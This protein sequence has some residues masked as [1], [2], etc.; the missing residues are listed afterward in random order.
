ME[1]E[2]VVITEFDSVETSDTVVLTPAPT[3]KPKK[4]KKYKIKTMTP[5]T[6]AWFALM[7]AFACLLVFEFYW[8]IV[9]ACKSLHDFTTGNIFGLPT[10]K[11]PAKDPW[12]KLDGFKGWY[13]LK[14]VM[15]LF[16][17]TTHGTHTV[18]FARLVYNSFAYTI[19]ATV[20]TILCQFFVAYACAKYNKYKW[21]LWIH[22]MVIVLMVVPIIGSQASELQMIKNLGIYDNIYAFSFLK[23]SFLGTNFLIF[24]SAVKGIP[25]DYWDAASLDG[26]GHCTLLF[27]LYMPM[28]STI[29]IGLGILAFMGYWND[30]SVSLYYLPTNPLLAYS[31]YCITNK[32]GNN[33]PHGLGI[34]GHFMAALVSAIPSIILFI[35]FRNKFL[36][37]ISMGG[38]KA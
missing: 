13:N 37:N 36:G 34:P 8:I 17:V 32:T 33:D 28:L 5:F 9:T 20:S 27:K 10:P 12:T 38:L 29:I 26:A 19:I 3:K 4:Q 6:W 35:C 16:P 23:W 14:H 1:N 31:L 25:Q 15:S 7:V 18:G 30:W 22:H 24:Y 11:N 21:T 2:N